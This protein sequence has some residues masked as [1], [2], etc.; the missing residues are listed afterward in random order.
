MRPCVAWISLLQPS[1]TQ[2]VSSRTEV[3]SVPR[4]GHIPYIGPSSL[5]LYLTESYSSFWSQLRH[6]FL[7]KSLLSKSRLGDLPL[8]FYSSPSFHHTAGQLPISW[9]VPSARLR[10]WE[11]Q[12]LGVS[13]SPL[14][15]QLLM[16]CL[17]YSKFPIHRNLS[18]WDISQSHKAVW[19]ANITNSVCHMQMVIDHHF[20]LWHWCSS[21]MFAV[22]L[23]R[24]QQFNEHY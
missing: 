1:L 9:S 20:G 11:E 6:H 5:H 16:Q 12:R 17:A 24:L 10:I 14:H 13:C 3:L 19:R 8:C 4:T 2:F 18:T 23:L 15:S 7:Q 22:V 21:G